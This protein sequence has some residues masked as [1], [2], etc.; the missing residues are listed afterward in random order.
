[1]NHAEWLRSDD[2]SQ[3]LEW[4]RSIMPEE[5]FDYRLRGYYLA[6]CRRIWRLLPSDAIRL[7]LEAAE[8]HLEGT[9]TPRDASY[10]AQLARDWGYMAE[11]DIYAIS[12]YN[13]VCDERELP[14]ESF[15]SQSGR[16]QRWVNEIA[17]IPSHKIR[18]MVRTTGDADTP[19]PRRLL[20]DATCFA[21][22]TIYWAV[23]SGDVRR[24]IEA[25]G[26]FLSPH[27]LRA[28][29]CHPPEISRCF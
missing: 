13:S 11:A 23:G 6:C 4:L 17:R 12:T 16:V 18:K 26:Q 29:V 8:R 24:G 20:D 10:W 25:Y 27:V 15:F 2:P 22:Y 5:V 28:T 9:T 3:M 7:G 21:F 14:D 19:S 1:M